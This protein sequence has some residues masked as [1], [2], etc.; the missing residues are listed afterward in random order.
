MNKK[1]FM[2]LVLTAVIAGSTFAGCANEEKP[3]NTTIS[4]NSNE[5]SVNNGSADEPEKKAKPSGNLLDKVTAAEVSRMKLEEKIEQIIQ[6]EIKIVSYT[7]PE[8]TVPELMKKNRQ[9]LRLSLR[10]SDWSTRPI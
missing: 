4:K 3:Q 6:V 5:P 7:E 10:S 1:R 9:Q 2:S 8:Y